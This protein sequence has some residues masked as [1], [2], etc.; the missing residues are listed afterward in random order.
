M[1][2]NPQFNDLEQPETIKSHIQELKKP[3]VQKYAE[4]E[5]KATDVIPP[6]KTAW[7]QEKRNITAILGTLG[8]FSLII[9]KAKSRKSF[10]INIAVSTVLKKDKLLNQFKGA[11]PDD[12]RKVLYFDTEQ[13]KY[14]VQ[15]ALKRVCKQISEDIPKDLKVYYLR[16]KKPSERLKIIEE[17]I[18]K[19]ENLG[20][21]VIDGIKDL[22]TSINDEAEATMIASKLLKWTEELDIHIVTVLHQNK[23]DNNA[24]GHIGTEL[25]N[26][27]ETVLSVTKNEQ[28]KD[29]SVVEAQLCRNIDPEPFAF[30]I[31]AEGVP[32]IVDD[33]EIRT[34]TKKNK[35]DVLDLEPK[36][37]YSM[38]ETVYSNGKS[39]TYSELVIQM[40]I[41]YKKYFNNKLGDNRA[42]ELITRCKNE[43]WLKQVKNKGAYFLEKFNSTNGSIF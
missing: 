9:G 42:K 41:A 23:S 8:N 32:V 22:V 34:E 1:N 27:A 24:R 10:F 33:F 37:I 15:L 43:N 11:L 16:S 19:T 6:P 20:F 28:D 35:F 4:L 38:L 26:K 29:I 36:K 14:H 18:Y 30:E 7:K 31:D 13:G 2:L 25:I 40:K 3:P 21:V 12:K 5:V 39:F 17:I